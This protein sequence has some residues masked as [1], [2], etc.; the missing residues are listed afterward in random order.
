MR[1]KFLVLFVVVGVLAGC[2]GAP[3]AQVPTNASATVSTPNA[4]VA[5]NTAN[6]PA[7]PTVGAATATTVPTP[8]STPKPLR[9]ITL[10]MSY[11]PNVQF[12]AYY[13]AAAHG[14][15]AD[16][17]LDVTFD[18]NF[19]NDVTQRAAAW[20]DSKVEF[21]TASGTS[22]LLARQQQLP[23]KTV[24]TLYQA[25][26]VVF[27][28]KEASNIKTIADL[29][30]KTI[31]IPGRFGESYYALLALLYANKWQ[32]SDLNVVEIGFTQAQAVLE[33]KVQVAVGYAMNE[34]VI[35]EQQGQKVVTLNVSD[36]FPLASNGV[37][38]SEKLLAQ[39]PALVRAFIGASLKGLTDTLTDPEEAFQVSIA[40][41]PEAN[42]GNKE[43]QR[44]VLTK[45]LPF[46]FNQQTRAFGLGYTDLATWQ[47]TEE[48]MRASGL[49][50]EP[51]KVEDGFTNEFLK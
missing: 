31:G 41:I 25:F 9:K 5:P 20:P 43:L 14:Y 49:L 27:F 2:G 42:L 11:I 36:I 35:L 37:V 47:K 46:W 8:Q 40:Q 24:M 28:S 33:D 19:E 26:P 21:A 15:Y 38:V 16:A 32:E 22:V 4:P 13:V 30:G 44:T 39:D 29:K 45:S 48:F 23:I 51:V 6:A 18:Y 10:A 1:Y 7:V 12:A 50:K 3:A 34:P 17:G